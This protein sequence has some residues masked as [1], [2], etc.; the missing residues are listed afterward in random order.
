M[1]MNPAGGASNIPNSLGFSPLSNSAHQQQEE[2]TMSGAQQM[3]SSHQIMNNGPF[4]MYQQAGLF[5][6]SQGFANPT[7]NIFARNLHAGLQQQHNGLMMSNPSNINGRPM[8]FSSGG[9][10]QHERIVAPDFS[11][12]APSAAGTADLEP[13]P[14]NVHRNPQHQA[15]LH[16]ML[17]ESVSFVMGEDGGAKKISGNDKKRKRDD[18]EGM[19]SI[20]DSDPERFRAYQAEQWDQRLD[21]LFEFRR[22]HGHCSVPYDYPAN[23]T[24]ARWVKR[25]RYQYKLFKEGQNSAMTQRRIEALEAAGFV[26][27]TYTAAWERRISELRAFK[28]E[29]GNCNVPATYRANKKLAAWVKC[30]RRQYKLFQEGKPN[31][32]TQDRIDALNQMGFH[33]EMRSYR[34]RSVEE[35]PSSN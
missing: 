3:Y 19:E 31:T 20:K 4:N 9:D 28:A 13:L 7:N 14:M 26:W 33:W 15:A 27:D 8:G 10:L 17:N 16:S 23:P 24:L 6:A 12:F 5:A 21:D 29:N 25:Q 18:S 1:E 35:A 30:Q 22:I 11:I 34:S 2:E 32:L